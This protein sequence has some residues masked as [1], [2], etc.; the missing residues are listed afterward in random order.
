MPVLVLPRPEVSEKIFKL[1]HYATRTHSRVV[2]ALVLCV[3]R[4]RKVS[5]T[6]GT[7]AWLQYYVIEISYAYFAVCTREL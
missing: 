4:S 5:V 3:N 6:S 1:G 2:V 7:G